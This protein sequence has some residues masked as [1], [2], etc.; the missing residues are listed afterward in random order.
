[1]K[2]RG[3]CL[4]TQSLFSERCSGRLCTLSWITSHPSS[5]L[6]GRGKCT[7][8]VGVVRFCHNDYALPHD[9]VC[10]NWLDTAFLVLHLRDLRSYSK[11]VGWIMMVVMVGRESV[12]VCV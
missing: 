4:H 10:P 6:K 3:A 2:A 1:M 9:V 11:Q 7:V 12:C 5:D 8:H